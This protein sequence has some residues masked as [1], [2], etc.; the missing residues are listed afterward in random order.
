[1]TGTFR[2]EKIS[3]IKVGVLG[4]TGIVGQQFVRMLNGHP[5]FETA[6]LAASPAAAG[7]RYGDAV[8]WMLSGGCPSPAGRILLCRPTGSDLRRSGVHVVFSALPASVAGEMEEDLS[9][10]GFRVFTNAGAFRMH[11]GVPVVIPEVNPD[12]LG[13][14][15]GRE[16]GEGFI[17]AN[18]NCSTTGLVLALKPLEGFGIRSLQVA[19]FQALSGAGRSGLPA[20]RAFDNVIPLIPGEEEKMSRETN[21]IL[22]RREGGSITPADI[23]ITATCCR[24]PVRDGHL[25]AVTAEL[26]GDVDL[27]RIKRAFHD[28]KALPQ[29]LRLPSAPRRPL[30]IRGESDRPQPALDRLAGT[31]R[32]ARG[33]AVSIGRLSLRGRRLRFVLL[34]HNTIRGAAGTSLLNAEMAAARGLLDEGPSEGFRKEEPCGS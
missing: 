9:G 34:V 13:L 14:I 10:S 23:E 30:I 17:V 4:S 12:H 22:G 27:S 15:S 5:W 7:R 25:E 1:M 20:L 28:Y 21:R 31:P 19:T 26:E 32:S 6:A 2:Q 24:V 18:A 33:M 11:P 3:K 16:S 29:R 8:D